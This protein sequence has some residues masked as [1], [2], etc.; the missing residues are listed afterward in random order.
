MRQSKVIVWRKPKVDILGECGFSFWEKRTLQC[1]ITCFKDGSE[2][3]PSW[4]I[5]FNFGWVDIFYAQFKWNSH[6]QIAK[7]AQLFSNNFS[8]HTFH[9]EWNFDS[10]QSP[11]LLSMFWNF[12]T[13]SQLIS[14]KFAENPGVDSLT[15]L[16][17]RWA[18]LSSKMVP[19]VLWRNSF[20]VTFPSVLFT[21]KF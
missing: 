9:K 4:L 20:K 2:L 3:R 5:I 10:I 1:T 18:Y 16:M 15:K 12:L 14:W 17:L 13:A 21:T 19:H 6:K 8:K 11:N 7:C